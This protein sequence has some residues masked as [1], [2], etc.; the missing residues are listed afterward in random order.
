VRADGPPVLVMLD[1]GYNVTRLQ[2]LL[3]GVPV[4][5][6]A[7]MRS[8][9]VLA[10]PAPDK[11]Y[12][13]PGRTPLHGPPLACRD[14]ATWPE[15]MTRQQGE[16]PRYGP[17]EILAWARLHPR[18]H[19][20][21]GG[22]EDWP[23]GQQLPLVEGTVIRLAVASREP[24]WLW[25]SDPAAGPELITAAWQGYL[26]RFDIEHV[27]RFLKHTLGWDKPRLRDPRAADRWT[28]LLIACWNQLYLA[29]S[30]AADIHLPWHKP[31]PPAMMT[32][33]RV[34]AAFPSLHPALPA[35]ASPPKP[36]RPGPGRP[37]GAKN[38]HKAPRHRTGKTSTKTRQHKKKRAKHT[39]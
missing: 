18:L 11:E 31:L 13:M 7:R 23:P 28:W 8:N 37:R 30:L 14:P 19:R 27:F 6:V 2:V 38:N 4:V 12:G 5:L 33:G 22:W 24:M 3:A 9:R 25:C 1:A 15:G 32:P 10:R 34:R 17:A 39:G 21:S 36:S 16:H 20:N 35:L 26:R 29:R